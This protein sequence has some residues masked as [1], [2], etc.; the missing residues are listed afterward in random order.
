MAL[1]SS[2]IYAI[3]V[4]VF[5]RGMI[6]NGLL[7]M[8]RRTFIATATYWRP[9]WKLGGIIT[10]VGGSLMFVGLFLFFVVIGA[11][12]AF[13]RRSAAVMDIPFSETLTAPALVGW[14]PRLDR[15]GLWAVAAVVLIVLAYGPFY[16]M[17]LPPHFTSAGLKIW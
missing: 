17:Y 14:E 12:I 15:I 5:A 6:S 2:W 16:L 7:G 9:E 3:G 13:G 4:F 11:T 1:V 8:P 10:G